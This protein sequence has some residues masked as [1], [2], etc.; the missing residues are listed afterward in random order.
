MLPRKPILEIKR[1]TQEN[2]FFF[3]PCQ[4]GALSGRKDDNT[5]EKTIERDEKLRTFFEQLSITVNE[6][7]IIINTVL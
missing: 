3:L 2:L 1:N 5:E 4:L 7:N 6:I